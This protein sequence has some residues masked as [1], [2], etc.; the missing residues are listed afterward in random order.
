M[1]PIIT[2]ALTAVL[3]FMFAS[4]ADAKPEYYTKEQD[5]IKMIHSECIK[6]ILDDKTCC[7]LY[8]YLNADS[9]YVF[10]VKCTCTGIEGWTKQ[11]QLF[12]IDC[13]TRKAE[14]I[15]DCAAIAV[16]EQESFVVARGRVAN[17]E[18][19]SSPADEIWAFHEYHCLAQQLKRTIVFQCICH[20]NDT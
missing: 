3:A 15:L 18:Y 6:K 20:N 9:R 16:N 12:K 13:H 2:F 10:I 7:P 14:F 5:S 8:C 19:V 1:K 4:N 17:A 11:Y